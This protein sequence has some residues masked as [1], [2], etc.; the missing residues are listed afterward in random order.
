MARR[1]PGSSRPRSPPQPV[2]QLVDPVFRSLK[3]DETARSFRA[4]RAFAQ[5]AGPRLRR[6]ARAEKLRG[7]TLYVRVSSSAWS[8]E[9][10]AFIAPLLDKI[11][12]TPGGEAVEDLRFTVGPFDDLPDWEGE[13]QAA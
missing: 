2:A 1:P 7:K 11:R 4:Q 12:R 5:A 10:H 6:V 9:L 8:Q 13:T 3:L